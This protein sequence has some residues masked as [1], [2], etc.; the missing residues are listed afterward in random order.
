[1]GNW[2]RAGWNHIVMEIGVLVFVTGWKKEE[3]RIPIGCFR[4]EE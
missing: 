2:T 1:M 4:M 3:S